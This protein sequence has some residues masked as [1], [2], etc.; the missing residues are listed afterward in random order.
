MK[1]LPQHA[2]QALEIMQR[3]MPLVPHRREYLDLV[4]ILQAPGR[5]KE[6]HDQFTTIR[7][8][9]TLPFERQKKKDSEAYFVFVAEQAAKTV[10]NCSGES[11]PFDDDSFE[12]LLRCEKEFLDEVKK[13]ANQTSQPTR[14][15]RG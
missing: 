7:T 2:K 11:A 15:A 1:Y 14:F 5:W 13:E 9:I 10:Y 8:K 12:W 6:A 3:C 4:D